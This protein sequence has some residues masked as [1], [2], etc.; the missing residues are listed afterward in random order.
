[1]ICENPDCQ[2]KQESHMLGEFNCTVVI[3]K[4]YSKDKK[5]FGT[6]AMEVPAQRLCPCEAF[7]GPD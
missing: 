5:D 6:V 7:I 2:H 1:M 4:I 3:E